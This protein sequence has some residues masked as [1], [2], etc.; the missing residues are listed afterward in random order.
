MRA[1]QPKRP[2]SKAV[3]REEVGLEGRNDALAETEPPHRGDG[4]VL[5]GQPEV[6]CG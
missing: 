5:E 1:I 6:D 2:T 3:E 4:E